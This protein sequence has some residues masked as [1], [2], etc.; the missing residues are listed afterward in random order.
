MTGLS[1]CVSDPCFDL[2]TGNNYIEINVQSN[3]ANT[4]RL[5]NACSSFDQRLRPWAN[6]NPNLQRWASGRHIATC[7]IAEK[8]ILRNRL[9]IIQV[10]LAQNNTARLKNSDHYNSYTS[11]LILHWSPAKQQNYVFI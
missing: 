7:E 11:L 8:L 10:Q 1:A 6:V 5:A 2:Y 3:K 9:S 4:I